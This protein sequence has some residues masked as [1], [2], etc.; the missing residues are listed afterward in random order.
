[1]TPLHM[2]VHRVVALSALLPA[3]LAAGWGTVLAQDSHLQLTE[4]NVDWRTGVGSKYIE[5]HNPTPGDLVLTH[6]YLTNANFGVNQYYNLV[7]YAEAGGG[8]GGKFNCRFPAGAS[9]AAG[10]TLV[11]SVQGS[12]AFTAAYGY[13]PD[14]ELYEDGTVLDAVAEMVPAFPGTIGSGLA[15][16]GDN[17]PDVY[18]QSGSLMLYR[19]D[20]QTD[21]VQDLDYV[22][23]GHSVSG[24]TATYVDK[25]GILI[26]GPDVDE[27]ASMY[28]DDTP[29]GS[30]DS[31]NPTGVHTFGTS[32]QR[33][34]ADEGLEVDTGGNGIDFHDETSENLGTTWNI[35]TYAAAGP[36]ALRYAPTPVVTEATLTPS[37][38]VAGEAVAVTIPVLSF[39]GVSG[40]DVFYALDGG[41]ANTVAA[42]DGGDG[43]WNATIPGQALDTQLVW[44]VEATSSGGTTAVWP[45]HAP[46]GALTAVFGEAPDPSDGPVHL[47]LTEVRYYSSNFVEIHN[48]FA[49][50]VE[51]DDYYLSDA[52]YYAQSGYWNVTR[53]DAS[54]SNVGGGNYGDFVARFPAGATLLA[55]A[56]I[57]VAVEGSDA[58]SAEYSLLPSYE[59]YEDGTEEDDV[60]D[61]VA[62]YTGAIVGDGSN[63]PFFTP[64]NEGN[65]QGEVIVLFYWDGETDLVTDVDMLGWGYG[66]NS[67]V[68]KSGVSVDGPDA[69]TVPTAFQDEIGLATS[70][71]MTV[72]LSDGFSYH[73]TNLN[74]TGETTAGGNGPGGHDETSEDFNDTWSVLE[75]DPATPPPPD[76]A[77]AGVELLLPAR[78]FLPKLG[79]I[80]PIRFRSLPGYQTTVRILDLE[81]RMVKTVFDSRSDG[82]AAVIPGTYSRVNWDGRDREFERVSPGLYVI[83]LSAVDVMTGDQHEKTGPVVVAARMK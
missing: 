22:C 61:M 45:V 53:T 44:W 38:P 36:P 9:I 82:V 60:E 71:N 48:P 40:V 56:S 28:A 67:L 24:A 35:A 70:R 50:D 3:V 68:D 75:V 54:T 74:E 49:F 42:A 2:K 76:V 1:M 63:D 83:H 16:P 72:Q 14:F 17:T 31:V 4:V 78:T 57:T 21:L 77:N 15:D 29:I 52:L 43:T 13:L 81:G 55:G 20:G 41:A 32:L 46:I 66:N 47:L 30:Q 12:A 10:D 80:F 18:Y 39:A 25:S 11:I 7:N 5:I 19:W 69:D 51:L 62:P 23:W 6:V 79:G 64:V 59:L 34:A 65:G 27:T 26:D 58:F 8:A 33:V 37:A 73:R